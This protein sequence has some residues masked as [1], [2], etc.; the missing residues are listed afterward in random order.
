MNEPG[1]VTISMNELRRVK[2][3]ESVVEGRLSGVRAAEQLGLSE[4]QVGIRGRRNSGPAFVLEATGHALRVS[5]VAFG[6]IH[7]VAFRPRRRA[8]ARVSVTMMIASSSRRS[9]ASCWVG[10]R[11]DSFS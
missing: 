7:A 6:G 9:S 3:I 1:L 8:A 4:R 10:V 5:G 2:V 11:A